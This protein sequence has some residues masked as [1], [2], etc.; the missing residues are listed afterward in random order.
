MLL[1]T[2]DDY[3]TIYWNNDTSLFFQDR[4]NIFHPY[5]RQYFSVLLTITFYFL[6]FYKSLKSTQNRKFV[7]SP[8]I[9]LI[10]ML[11][12]S[13]FIQFDP[14]TGDMMKN[15]YYSFLLLISFIFILIELLQRLKDPLNLLFSILFVFSS[16][17]LIGFP[18][19]QTENFEIKYTQTYQQHII[20]NF[21]VTFQVRKVTVT[22][23]N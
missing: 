12:V 6:I 20:V 7:I 1:E 18:K 10:I 22:N 14:N 17:F 13:L 21:T 23:L 15:Y 19:E 4:I 16:L 9:G 2:F 11:F 5:S 3:F 8:F